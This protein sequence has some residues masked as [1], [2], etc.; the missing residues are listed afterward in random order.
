M[1]YFIVDKE[2]LIETLRD[3]K[4]NR[5]LSSESEAI[6]KPLVGGKALLS[7]SFV[8]ASSTFSSRIDD[9]YSKGKTVVANF[10]DCDLECSIL[11]PP[12]ENDWV[13]GIRKGD[14]F[15]SEVKVLALDNLYQ[16]V[17]F[18]QD[19]Q[20]NEEVTEGIEEENEKL[21][22]IVTVD[23]E[24]GEKSESGD[25]K[26][27]EIVSDLGN[28]EK[29][30]PIQEDVSLVGVSENVTEE[31][32]EQSPVVSENSLDGEKEKILEPQEIDEDKLENPKLPDL[33]LTKRDTNRKFSNK[34]RKEKFK[35]EE[36]PPPIPSLKVQKKAR[37]I[38][39]RELE[40]IRDKRYDDGAASLTDEENELLSLAKAR[41]KLLSTQTTNSTNSERSS[42]KRPSRPQQ[43][44]DENMVTLGCR[45]IFGVLFGFCGLQALVQ[46][47]GIVAII[48]IGIAWYLLNPIIKKFKED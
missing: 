25:N 37:E 15:E 5:R 4:E 29:T 39:Y 45:G 27:K 22:S 44:A 20:A 16:R 6:I 46:G 33:K 30:K 42:R 21:K 3:L 28:D 35:T 34:G 17:I 11:F 10:L 48:T 31:G 14:E 9:S 38:D 2:K 1:I 36:E 8:E 19:F 47:S 23:T 40:R 12:S 41:S 13:D 43:K 26:E 7:F 18:G 32:S 24:R